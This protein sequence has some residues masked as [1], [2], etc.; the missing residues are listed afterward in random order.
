MKKLAGMLLLLVLMFSCV[1]SNIT[2]D[3]D[4]VAIPFP[5]D[6]VSKDFPDYAGKVFEPGIYLFPSGF[7]SNSGQNGITTRLIQYQIDD[8]MVISYLNPDPRDQGDHRLKFQDG[9][10]LAIDFK[11]TWGLKA[12]VETGKIDI[13]T[14][15]AVLNKLNPKENRYTI[16]AMIVEYA[17]D[18]ATNTIRSEF[19]SIAN[20]FEFSSKYYATIGDILKEKINAR[21]PKDCPVMVKSILVSNDT[22]EETTKAAMVIKSAIERDIELI[23]EIG[24]YLKNYPEV[25][26]YLQL[27]FAENNTAKIGSF[28]MGSSGVVR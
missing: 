5:Q 12:D 10:A 27:K 1:P 26:P 8:N 28:I 23:R 20:Y 7:F 18:L 4:F 25:I 6:R 17:I 24:P 11:T 9:T 3:P 16:Q 14:L 2:V 22:P 19:K 13:D 21:L 15:L